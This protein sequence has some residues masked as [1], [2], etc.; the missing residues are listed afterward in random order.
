MV[1]KIRTGKKIAGVVYYN[2]DKVLEGKTVLLAA[3]CFAADPQ[4]LTVQMK[5]NRFQHLTKL[6]ERA[7]T[8]ALH[9]SLNFHKK[10]CLNEEKMIQIAHQYMEGIGFGQQPYLIYAHQDAHHPHLHIATTNIQADGSR[11]SLHDIGKNVS[12]PLRKELEQRYGLIVAEGREPAHQ[13]EKPSLKQLEYGEKALKKSLSNLTRAVRAQYIYSGLNE[14]NAILKRYNAIA[15]PGTTGSRMEAN[16]GLLY[17]VLDNNGK[18]VG[19]PIKASALN[20]KP[21]LRNLEQDFLQKATLKTKLKPGIRH[22]LDML[23]AGGVKSMA[24]FQHR[25]SKTNIDLILSRTAEGRVFGMTYI[26][27][28]SKAVMKGSELGKAYSALGIASRLQPSGM[29]SQ[30]MTTTLETINQQNHESALEQT[31]LDISALYQTD[32][33]QPV[34][35]LLK[36]KKK[37][38]RFMGREAQR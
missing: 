34:S 26:D 32:Y 11:I 4:E 1:V 5:I 13:I 17:A 27:H 37:K 31:G 6:N 14:F 38:K 19:V 10:D 35:P 22:K 24:D 33:A 29:P 8:N 16:R 23:L 12:E 21:I 20:G 36:R 25:L 18:P 30:K 7:K 9:I 3:N 15:I 2:E 28:D